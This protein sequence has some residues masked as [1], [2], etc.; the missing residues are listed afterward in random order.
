MNLK[1][2]SASFMLPQGVYQVIVNAPGPIL[3]Q[4]LCVESPA[5]IYSTAGVGSPVLINVI[6]DG[7]VSVFFTDTFPGDNIGA[8]ATV[9]FT[10]VQPQTGS[11]FVTSTPTGAKVSL[12]GKNT[13]KV[14]PATLEN[15]YTG[16]HIVAVLF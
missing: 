10:W 6:G 16:T 4:T 12:D 2:K 1:K 7:L 15:V 5:G 9:T 13:G 14:T 8:N 3:S 11:I